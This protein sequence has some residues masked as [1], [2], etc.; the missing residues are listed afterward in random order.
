MAKK[1][2]AGNSEYLMEVVRGHSK[3]PLYVTSVG[4]T[5]TSAAKNIQSMAGKYR[6]PDILSY[7]DQ[8]TKLFKTG[9]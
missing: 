4:V 1:P 5:L 6:M 7:L 8:Q 9:E 2:F 3:H